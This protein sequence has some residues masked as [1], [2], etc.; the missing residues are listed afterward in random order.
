MSDEKIYKISQTRVNGEVVRSVFA[1]I[2][3][4]HIQTVLDMFDKN[5]RKVK[6]VKN[7][8]VI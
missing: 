7:V 3:H 2:N 4:M 8:E 5:K 6:N 1:K